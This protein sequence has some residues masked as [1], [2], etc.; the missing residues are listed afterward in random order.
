[1]FGLPV[2]LEMVR[3]GSINVFLTTIRFRFC[4]L[5]FGFVIPEGLGLEKE[6]FYF[7]DFLKRIFELK[8]EGWG[9]VFLFN[10]NFIY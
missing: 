6:F 4:F 10:F 2:D 5:M 1:M 8:K 3:L 7:F 9:I